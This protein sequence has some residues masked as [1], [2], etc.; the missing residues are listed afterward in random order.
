MKVVEAAGGLV[1]REYH[2][3]VQILLIFRRGVWD[4]PKGKKESDEDVEACAIRETEEETGVSVEVV[5]FLTET[6]HE[7]KERGEKI[8][9]RTHWFLM[10]PV[11]QDPQLN[12][13]IEEEIEM[14]KWVDLEK[15]KEIVGFENLLQVIQA[16]EYKK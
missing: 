11:R 1:Q 16:Y 8:G 12:P 7:Y 5:D 10:Q 14:A 15:A 9:K 4:L 3:R 6:W 2:G 13:Q